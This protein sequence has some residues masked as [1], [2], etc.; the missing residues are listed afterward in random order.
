M[1]T[2]HALDSLRTQALQLGP[3]ARVELAHALVESLNGLS[4]A[5]IAALWL[6]EAKRR[7]VE[8]ES[9]AVAGVSGPDVFS[10]IRAHYSK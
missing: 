3:D 6:A 1:T 5:E 9:G 4:E 10:R 7:D 2:K 8:M